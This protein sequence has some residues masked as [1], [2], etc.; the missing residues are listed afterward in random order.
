MRA[1]SWTSIMSRKMGGAGK[2][3]V[4]PLKSGA[5]RFGAGMVMMDVA[6]EMVRWEPVVAS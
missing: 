3:S 1:L 4:S 2:L 5:A 6:M